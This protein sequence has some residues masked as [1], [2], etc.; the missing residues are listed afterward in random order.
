MS[1]PAKPTD[2]EILLARIAVGY[3][4]QLRWYGLLRDLG[5]DWAGEVHD[6]LKTVHDRNL[7]ELNERIKELAA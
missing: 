2:E 1:K 4:S 5:H 7:R 3:H 6:R